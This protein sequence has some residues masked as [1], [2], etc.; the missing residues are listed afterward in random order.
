MTTEKKNRIIILAT[1]LLIILI[2]I[3]VWKNILDG[4][5]LIYEMLKLSFND[6]HLFLKHLDK[7]FLD[8]L[9]S[10]FFILVFI[11]TS[12]LFLFINFIRIPNPRWLK[13]LIN[14]PQKFVI[15]LCFLVFILFLST[16]TPVLSPSNPMTQKNVALTRL[17]PP[18]SKLNYFELDLKFENKVEETKSKIPFFDNLERRVYFTSYQ[19][20]NNNLLYTQKSISYS[21]ELSKTR[22]IE[23]IPLIY[24]KLFILGTD[25]YGRD[26]L[27]R[28]LFSIRLSLFIGISSISL[29]FL[30]GALI[31]YSAAIFGNIVDKI[32]MRIVDL[33]L[34]IPI[35]FFVIFLIAF[36]G[37]S[38]LLLIVVFGLS[39]WMYIALLARNES[40]NCLK[41]EFIQIQFLIGQKKRKIIL[42]H[43][44]PNTILPIIVTMI[45]QLS[46]VIIAESALSFLGLGVQPPTPTLGGM[47]KIGYDY[48]SNGWWI[49]IISGS[50]LVYLI[51]SFNIL[52]EGLKKLFK[53]Q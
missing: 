51:F 13:K 32:L 6:W 18:F 50:V 11:L 26:I 41:K 27:S 31:G 42:Y 49:I 16:T 36:L 29:S 2:S 19:I 40:L 4:Y 9:I 28:I 44:L 5:V 53:Y 3:L 35:L 47:I 17:L 52:G 1:A 46:N 14:L 22:H 33:F 48:M 45:F 7:K 43:L 15:G 25:E 21:I 38:I 23:N 24:Q 39:G 34:S 30:I 10:N 12:I 37:N 20:K 8:F